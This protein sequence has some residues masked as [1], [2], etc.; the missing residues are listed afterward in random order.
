MGTNNI[1]FPGEIRKNI[2]TFGLKKKKKVLSRAMVQEKETDT[3]SEYPDH[4]AHFSSLIR[5]FLFVDTVCSSWWFCILKWALK[6][7][8][9]PWVCALLSINVISTLS[10]VL[11]LFS[12]VAEIQYNLNGLNTDGSFTVDDSNSFFS[13]YKIL[14]IAQENKYLMIFSYS[15]MELY[16]VCTH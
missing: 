5:V 11:P 9:R 15:I 13:T 3:D 16:V 8:I 4:L 6:T 12:R 2:N 10:H 7:E 14:P 1:C